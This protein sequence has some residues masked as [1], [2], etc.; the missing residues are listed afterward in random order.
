VNG[1]DVHSENMSRRVRKIARDPP[2]A[3]QAIDSPFFILRSP[4]KA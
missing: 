1:R 3:R 4:W 2:C